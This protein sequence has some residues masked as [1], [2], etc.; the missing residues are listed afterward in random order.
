MVANL[1]QTGKEHKNKCQHFER[2]KIFLP[3]L[4]SGKRLPCA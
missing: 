3:N 1:S 2:L 4:F